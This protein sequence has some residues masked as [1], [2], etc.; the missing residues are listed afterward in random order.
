VMEQDCIWAWNG[1]NC[2]LSRASFK[3]GNTI[4]VHSKGQVIVRAVML[5]SQS[6]LLRTSTAY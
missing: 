4:G 6:M 2:G 5:C 3:T 1:G